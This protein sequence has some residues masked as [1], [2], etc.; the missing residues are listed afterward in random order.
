M[1]LDGRR[2]MAER[3]IDFSGSGHWDQLGGHH[4]GVRQGWESHLP[5]PT[6]FNWQRRQ[7]MRRE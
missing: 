4:A 1:P 3:F 6:L 2:V 5:Q 7:L